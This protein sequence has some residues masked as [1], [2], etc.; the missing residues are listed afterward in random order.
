MSRS[1]CSSDGVRAATEDSQEAAVR[2][3][4]GERERC[5]RAAGQAEPLRVR[6]IDEAPRVRQRPGVVERGG[7][8]VEVELDEVARDDRSDE[9]D[10]LRSRERDD[11]VRHGL[12][13]GVDA[14][15]R[16][17]LRGPGVVKCCLATS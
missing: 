1:R 8:G 16:E 12:A 11:W 2:T 5:G 13:D 6:A 9:R 17:G 7:A 3:G 14:Y 15:E 4:A 10:F